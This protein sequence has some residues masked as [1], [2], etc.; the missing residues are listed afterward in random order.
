MRE[1]RSTEKGLSERDRE[2]DDGAIED[3]LASRTLGLN[4]VRRGLTGEG[5]A[6]E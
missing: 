5:R 3:T 6:E 2:I 4:E 1:W